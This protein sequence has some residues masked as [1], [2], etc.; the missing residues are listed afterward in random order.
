MVLWPRKTSLSAQA[1]RLYHNIGKVAIRMFLSAISFA[2][3]MCSIPAA[4]G[5]VSWWASGALNE[6]FPRIKV[7][8]LHELGVCTLAANRLATNFH[9]LRNVEVIDLRNN[10]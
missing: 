6:G 1:R 9:L 7:L 4:A 3:Q 5:G 8:Q 2:Q 10:I